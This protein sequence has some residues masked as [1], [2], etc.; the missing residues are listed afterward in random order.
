MRQTY[1]KVATFLRYNKWYMTTHALQ[2]AT[3]PFEAIV[4]GQKTIES[5]LYDEKRQ[6]IQLGDEIIFTNREAP[7]QTVAVIVVGLLR[8]DTFSALFRYNGPTRFGGESVEW[9]ENQIN[10]F[11]SID[12]QHIKGVVGIEFNRL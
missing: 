5:R 9:L 1:S 12:E 2:L 8:Y 11:Y 3:V 6:L 7:E 10:E 4:S